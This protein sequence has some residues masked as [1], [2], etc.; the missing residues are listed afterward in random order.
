M[1]IVC[2]LPSQHASVNKIL[3]I[4]KNYI[5]NFSSKTIHRHNNI[6]IKIISL[7][8]SQCSSYDCILWFFHF[9]F[10]FHN[11]NFFPFHNTSFHRHRIRQCN[12]R[13]HESRGHENKW[14]RW[15]R[16]R[17]G[18]EAGLKFIF[19]VLICWYLNERKIQWKCWKRFF[20]N[21]K[22]ENKNFEIEINFFVKAKTKVF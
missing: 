17:E 19:I 15:E 16:E 10:H 8:L 12:L 4:P 9:H 14:L 7:L 2:G 3:T 1:N 21:K 11:C 20:N 6:S 5:K 22:H 18:G 13:S